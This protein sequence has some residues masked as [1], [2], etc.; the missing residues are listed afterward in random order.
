MSGWKREAEVRSF[1][2]VIIERELFT[3]LFSFFR[4]HFQILIFFFPFYQ[5]HILININAKLTFADQQSWPLISIFFT[6]NKNICYW[7]P[8]VC[9]Q[10]VTGQFA[11]SGWT[12]WPRLTSPL[13]AGRFQIQ[14]GLWSCLGERIFYPF[15]CQARLEQNA[16]PC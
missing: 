16:R 10:P 4:V 6:K 11:S 9:D 14:P 8:T 7:K 12:H 15:L 2:S 5:K 1:I 13:S 3:S